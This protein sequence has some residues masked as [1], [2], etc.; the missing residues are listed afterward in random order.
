MQKTIVVSGVVRYQEQATG[1]L[2]LRLAWVPFIGDL[3]EAV[4][5][6]W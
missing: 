1:L 4:Q 5:V 6:V 3:S 2:Q